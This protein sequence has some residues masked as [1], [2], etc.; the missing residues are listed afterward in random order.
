MLQLY[1]NSVMFLGMHCMCTEP[2][3]VGCGFELDHGMLQEHLYSEQSSA[4][5][6]DG[7]QLARKSPKFDIIESAD[8]NIEHLN[9]CCRST[10]YISTSELEDVVPK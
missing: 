8:L 2:S 1:E 7:D 6:S 10:S 3:A 5:G 9:N 4:I